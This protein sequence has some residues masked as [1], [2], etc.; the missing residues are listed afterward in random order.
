MVS[1]VE[2][3]HGTEKDIIIISCVKSIE[4]TNENDLAAMT[5][6]L[7]VALTRARHSLFICG[8]LRYL[9]SNEIFKCAI[10][11]AEKRQ[12]IHRV[13]SFLHPSIIDMLVS[14]I[15][16]EEEKVF[17]GQLQSKMVSCSMQC[18]TQLF[19]YND[20]RILRRMNFHLLGRK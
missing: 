4:R 18:N 7:T 15:Q 9:L 10:L 17:I 13:S 20:V 3:F 5:E 19:S 14:K 16:I 2:G 1:T 8:Q 12:V 11:D 6:K